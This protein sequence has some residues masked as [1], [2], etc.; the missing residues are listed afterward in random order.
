MQLSTE[1]KESSAKSGG[2]KDSYL[3]WSLNKSLQLMLPDYSLP[4]LVGVKGEAGTFCA[5]GGTCVHVCVRPVYSVHLCIMAPCELC[6]WGRACPCA[7][8]LV[9]P[10]SGGP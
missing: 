7:C 8:M 4:T 6:G 2:G 10:I 1:G 5:G 9:S 3:I